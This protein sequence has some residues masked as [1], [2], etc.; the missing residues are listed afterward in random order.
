MERATK[1][2]GEGLAGGLVGRALVAES[3]KA[4]EQHPGTWVRVKDG[5]WARLHEGR[6]EQSCNPPSV[7]E[8]RMAAPTHVAPA[9]LKERKLPKRQPSVHYRRVARLMDGAA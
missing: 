9:S 6:L 2:G 8:R 1:K 3:R 5:L 4:A 7:R